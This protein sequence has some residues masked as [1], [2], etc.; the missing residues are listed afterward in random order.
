MRRKYCTWLYKRWTESLPVSLTD[1]FDCRFAKLSYLIF[2][3]TVTSDSEA[4]SLTSSENIN[5]HHHL[6]HSN[7]SLSTNGTL[8][9]NLKTVNTIVGNSNN[10]HVREDPYCLESHIKIINKKNN[11]DKLNRLLAELK[12][13]SR[14]DDQDAEMEEVIE[15]KNEMCVQDHNQHQSKLNGSSI[16]EVGANF[17]CGFVVLVYLQY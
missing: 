13:Y 12:E 11:Q 8:K 6:Q 3:F 17:I 5:H 4:G 1:T 16:C 10:G 7:T 2:S 14:E 9:N 15:D